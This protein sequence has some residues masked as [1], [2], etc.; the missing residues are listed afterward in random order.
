LTRRL[1]I[2]PELVADAARILRNIYRDVDRQWRQ[3]IEAILPVDVFGQP[4]D[5]DAINAVAK[6][7]D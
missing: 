2:N 4:A 1:E 7:M 3:R 6:N 5:M